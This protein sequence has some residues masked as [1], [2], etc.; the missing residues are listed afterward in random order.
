MKNKILS[1]NIILIL[2]FTSLISVNA[3]A[4]SPRVDLNDY[5]LTV[6][7]VNNV[8]ISGT[9]NTAKGQNIGLF[10]STGKVPL[11]YTTVKNT[12]SLSSFKIHVPSFVLKNKIN[13]FK[14]ISLPVRGVLN[15]SSPKTFTVKLN[16]SKKDQTI[17]ANDISVKVNE[18]KSINAKVNSN[19]SLTYVSKDPTIA[20]VD[21]NGIVVGRKLG[22]TSVTISQGG[23]NDYNPTTKVITVT[24][25]NN[26]DVKQ[27]QTITTTF[28]KYQ[29][30]DINKSTNLGA[31]ST[32]GLAC[33]YKSSQP[34]IVSVDSKGKLTA[35][36]AG[37]TK[38]TITQSGNS[39]FKAATKTVTVKVPKINSRSSA[40][41]PLFDACKTQAKW[42]KNYSYGKWSPVTIANT[43][44][45]GT[46]VTYVGVVLQ[47][48]NLLKNKQYVWHTG[49]GFGTGKLSGSYGNSVKNNFKV[50]YIKNKKLKTM[51]KSL[52]PGD[53]LMVDDNRSGNKGGGG[54]VFIYTGKYNGNSPIIW[55]NGSCSRVKKGKAGQHTYSGN[56]KL[57][58][59]LRPNTYNINTTCINGN[60]TDTHMYL[61]GQ[62][63]TISYKPISGKKIKSIKVDGQ[64]VNINKHKNSYTFNKLNKNHTITVVFN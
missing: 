47:R 64:N 30:A 21:A 35:K 31:K 4:P 15:A 50:T 39:N 22:T 29:F 13:T 37:I 54:H 48:A 49:S 57:R 14:V 20:T 10:D 11:S 60:I 33:T 28:D 62:K 38:I 7:D 63:A 27:P 1:I 51:K 59:I 56:R 23:N 34:S 8:Y 40:M 41:K 19:L 18:K 6:T 17:T 9:V 32:S 55:D 61:A 5:E 46:C 42:M 43:K 25:T 24:V 45:H 58:I 53:V 12:G 26:T 3:A 52:Q 2:L 36:K 16:S 44:K